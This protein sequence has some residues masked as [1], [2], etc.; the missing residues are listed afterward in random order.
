LWITSAKY[1]WAHKDSNLGP[2]DKSQRNGFQQKTYAGDSDPGWLLPE[3][4]R[5]AGARRYP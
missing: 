2:A 1:W 5:A 4:S 3:R